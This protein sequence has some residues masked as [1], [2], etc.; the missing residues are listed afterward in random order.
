ML[1]LA[2]MIALI[3]RVSKA[4]V[5]VNG[6]VI[7]EIKQGIVVF[8]GIEKEDSKKDIDYIVKKIVNLRIFEDAQGK[9]NLSV[10]DIKGEVLVVSE[11]TLAGDC[12]KGNRPSFDKAMPPEEAEKLYNDFIKS[13]KEKGIPVKEGIF[14]EF[15]HVCLINEGPVTFIINS[16]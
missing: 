10:S 12:R 9:M 6:K 13:L 5:Q 16:R 8:L 15:M 4:D 11:F 2:Y 14:R 3:Q 7:S 1:I